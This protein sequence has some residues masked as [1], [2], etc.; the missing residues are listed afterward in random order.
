M[1]TAH[2]NRKIIGLHTCQIVFIHKLCNVIR[3]LYYLYIQFEAHRFFLRFTFCCRIL[4]QD[5]I[6]MSLLQYWKFKYQ[7]LKSL[8]SFKRN[9][10]S[11]FISVFV[12]NGIR[13]LY[14]RYETSSETGREDIEFSFEE[15]YKW[16][17]LK[18]CSKFFV[19]HTWVLSRGH[20]VPAL[21]CHFYKIYRFP[22]HFCTK[23]PYTHYIKR[24]FIAE[25]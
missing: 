9:F 21:F 17:S 6:L 15:I 19:L 1:N 24:D 8:L 13:C 7:T 10:L 18:M 3:R 14:E 12:W 11:P 25:L 23:L 22:S 20:F 4:R 16:N 5:F 2:V